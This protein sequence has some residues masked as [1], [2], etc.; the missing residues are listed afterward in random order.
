MG[1]SPD[2]ELA[3]LRK[4]YELLEGD[5]KA[6]YETSQ[7]TIKQNRETIGALKRENKELRGQ[8][9]ARHGERGADKAKELGGGAEDLVKL[10]QYTTE[11]RRRFDDIH[12]LSLRKGEELDK[13]IDNMKDLERDGARASEEDSP[14][15]RHIR[16]L[17]NRLDKALIKYNEA[18]SIRKTYEQIVKRLREERIGFDNQL[19]AIERTLKAKEHDLE[20]LVLMSHDANH[21]K[22]VAKAELSKVDMQLMTE[23]GQR[24][25]DLQERRAQVRLKQEQNAR[26]EQRDK[27]RKDIQAEAQGDLSVEQEEAMKKA[28]VTN[29]LFH[30]E[31]EAKM[32]EEQKRVTTFEEAFRKIKE[33]TGVSDVNEVIQKFMT[34]ED[35]TKNLMSMTKEAQGRIDGLNEEREATKAR[36][37]EVKYSGAGAAGSRRI[38]D[39]YEQ[40]LLE[41]NGKCDRSRLKFERVARIL[42]AMKAGTEHLADKLEGIKIE[43][44]QIPVSD[45]TVVDVMMQC[46][47]K[48][49]KT[50]D[51]FQ[52]D[53]EAARSALLADTE[54]VKKLNLEVM[55]ENNVRID[56]FS[57]IYGSDDEDEDEEES[58]SDGEAGE[59]V[60][61]R[62]YMKNSAQQ[63][64]DKVNKKSK[65]ARRFGG[66]AGDMP[67]TPAAGGRRA[68]TKRSSISG[69][70]THGRKA[71]LA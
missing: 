49:L 26:M 35:T 25:K 48:L 55:P 53:E 9:A 1:L 17:E 29:Q 7:W 37:E 18:T 46:E 63:L 38:V 67:A 47:T 40:Q 11:L 5:R 65:K 33:A 32:A 19:A 30:A 54:K 52:G 6:Y 3:D 69:T 2:E 62:D 41:S 14:M 8:L 10:Q 16:M 66:N 23:R 27:M 68:S 71:G 22:E 34:Q 50:L 28:L 24:E 36:M 21:A 45:E 12:Q 59:D 60:P 13:K 43:A 20:E 44:P 61:D 64:T 31:N 70:G 51:V 56:R 39:E 58:A 4:K 15:T 42:I 57:G